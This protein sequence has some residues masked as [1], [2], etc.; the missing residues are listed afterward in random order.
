[1][2]TNHVRSILFTRICKN[3]NFK[4]VPRREERKG[5]QRE[6]GRRATRV[7]SLRVGGEGGRAVRVGSIREKGGREG[8]AGAKVVVA[9]SDLSFW[10][11]NSPIQRT[12]ENGQPLTSIFK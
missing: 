1:M 9:R 4:S 7:G 10:S 3:Q 6:S 2:H 5:G 12:R 8:D 11:S